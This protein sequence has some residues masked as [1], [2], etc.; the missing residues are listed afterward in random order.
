LRTILLSIVILLPLAGC[1][2]STGDVSGTVSIGS[3]PI[4]YG[5]VLFQTVS[6]P[7]K[8]CSGYIKDGSYTIK[9][10]PV[11]EV[12][13]AIESFPPPTVDPNPPKGLDLKIQKPSTTQQV[14]IPKKYRDVEKSGLKYT[15]TAGAQTKN[16]EL[17]K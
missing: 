2:P 16:F 4:P 10:V 1:A 5:R 15:V 8:T 17:T 14:P 9:S 3:K 6:E 13:V 12:K 11:G 7:H